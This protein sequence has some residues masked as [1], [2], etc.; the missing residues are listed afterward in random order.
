M[1]YWP[2]G[3]KE[4]Q[5]P[6]GFGKRGGFRGSV[7]NIW[8]KGFKLLSTTNATTTGEENNQISACMTM[9]NSEFKV[10][11]IS[12]L[13]EIHRPDNRTPLSFS[14]INQQI[15]NTI[16]VKSLND[17]SEEIPLA[18]CMD[19]IN[20][21]AISTLL[22]SGASDYCFADLSLFTSY[23]PFEQL[24]PR[25]TT[26]EGLTFN[27]V[28]K[29][30]VELQTNVNGQRRMITFDNALHIPGFRSNLISV[31]R[32]S[33][34]GAE[35]HFKNNKAVIKT[36]NGTDII[37]ATQSGLLYVV[38]IDKIQPIAF[39]AQSK[40]KL[41]SFVTWHR[42]LAYAG[43][44]T[45]HQMMTKNL[46]DGLNI[47]GELSIGGLCKDCIYGKHTAHLYSDN[48]PREKDIFEHIHINI[49]D[50]FQVQLAGSA[51]YFMIIIDGF[52]S[53]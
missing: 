2:E 6:P 21:T 44:E 43:A 41:T 9:G 13:N 15:H 12:T 1:C 7:A 45:I 27:V 28:G 25:L 11:T 31:A 3:G 14:V 23:T 18:C 49:W 46:V 36:K 53:Y 38:N 32:L 24:S 22:D 26:E 48:K 5:F 34:K 8:Q 51:L 37:S 16:E 29:G 17:I 42:Y 52:S 33:T 20:K 39:M 50:L 10:P 30:S 4:G 35:A 47:Y 19:S 40:Q